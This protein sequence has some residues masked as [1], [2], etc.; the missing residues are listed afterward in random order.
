MVIIRDACRTYH[1]NTSYPEKALLK[2]LKRAECK[3]FLLALSALVSTPL[4]AQVKWW[5]IYDFQ[6]L[7]GGE[8]SR[9]D[10]NS[11]PND[12]LQVN[13][14]QFQLFLQADVDDN[15]SFTTCLANSPQDSPNFKGVTFQLAYVTFSN[16]VRNA[17]SISAGKIVTPFGLFAKRQLATENPFIGYPLFFVYPQNVSPQTG[18]L[19]QSEV[20]AASARYGGRL[21]TIYTGA[22]FMG[23]EAFGSFLDDFLQYDVALTNAPLS[24]TSSDFNVNDNPSVDGRISLHPAIWGTFGFSYSSGPFMSSSSVNQDFQQTYSSLNQY[25]Q[26]T[27]GADAEL[28]YLYYELDAEYIFNR[29]KSPYIISNSNYQYVSG[30]PPGTWLNLDSQELLVD[31]KIDAAFFPGLFLALRYNPLWFGNIT[32]P[33]QY[34]PTHGR[35]ITW[36]NNVRRYVIGLGYKPVRS[37]VVKLDYEKTDVSTTPKPAL[38]VFGLA[39]VVSF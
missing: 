22:Y 16:L 20:A 25:A 3:L 24:S 13:V 26:T 36:D 39:V 28:S 1:R 15:I 9:E 11:L 32:D 2:F 6:I 33:D 8:D 17:L 23:A 37:V 4:R 29:F 30:L 35:S 10:L 18:Y 7:K 27:L 34:S 31:L 5:G 12:Y 19:D 38:D 14:H 21:N